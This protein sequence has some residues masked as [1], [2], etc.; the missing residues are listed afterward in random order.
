M[1]KILKKLKKIKKLKI[2]ILLGGLCI[3][4]P[5]FSDVLPVI[6]PV[7]IGKVMDELKVLKDSYT[8]LQNQYS[9]ITGSYGFGN[10]SNGL[11]ELKNREWAPSDWNSALK[12]LAGGSSDRYQELLNQYKQ[13]H[14]VL[15]AQTY[16]KGSDQN[17][18]KTYQ[19]QVATNQVSTATATY[20]FNDLNQHLETLQSLSAQIEN[21]KNTN[22]KS[23]IDLNTRIEVELGYISIEELRMQSLL[24]QQTADLSASKISSENQAAQFNQAG[25]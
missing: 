19:N 13:N 9:A 17:L 11:A 12:N 5:S 14:L 16:L 1:L 4:F 25:E 24:N 6:D 21:P 23:A 10:L 20:E 2:L 3:Y 7:E 22:I 15:D 18:T 8:Q